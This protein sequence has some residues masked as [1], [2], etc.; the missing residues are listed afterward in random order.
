MQRTLCEKFL[1]GRVN[2]MA[3]TL[4]PLSIVAADTIAAFMG[5]LRREVDLKPATLRK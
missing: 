4:R 5:D 3:L 2:V 1:R